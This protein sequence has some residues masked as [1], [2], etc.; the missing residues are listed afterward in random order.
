MKSTKPINAFAPHE[1]NR[2]Q[3]PLVLA[4]VFFMVV[5]ALDGILAKPLPNLYMTLYGVASSCYILLYNSLVARSIIFRSRY[6]WVNSIASGIG[7]GLLTYILPSH[8]HELFHILIVFSAIVTATISGRYYTY[9]NLLIILIISIPG[10]ITEAFNYQNILEYSA[11]FVISIIVVET[12]LRIK[13]TAQQHIL[14]L[15][16]I[17]K[18][19]HQLMQSLKTDQVLSLLNATILD[20]IEA[21]T[22]FIGILKD[23]EI[24]LDLFY[25]DGE[26]FNGIRVPIE[27]SLSSWVINNQKAL[28]LPDL[29][30]DVQLTG[31]KDQIIGKEKT[32]L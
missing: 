25:D 10:S 23:D 20:T 12:Y 26:F 1:V 24:Q 9:T 6:S 19:S 30:E 27:G 3:A 13:D 15:E 16:T 17:N 2:F 14:R 8:L 22:Y 28:F 31:V 11:P 18:I 4:S 5:I 32:S 7:L 29:R 21:D